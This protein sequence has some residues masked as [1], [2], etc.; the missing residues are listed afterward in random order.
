M[1]NKKQTPKGERKISECSKEM[2]KG[3][4]NKNEK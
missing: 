4:I 1:E 2:M 3:G